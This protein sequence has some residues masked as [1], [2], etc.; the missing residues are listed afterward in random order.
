MEKKSI[1]RVVSLAVLLALLIGVM[2]LLKI[3]TGLADDAK[4]ISARVNGFPQTDGANLVDIM[5]K[6][7]LNYIESVE[8]VSGVITEADFRDLKA[9][10]L[11]S[12]LNLIVMKT[13]Q[14]PSITDPT[15]FDGCPSTRSIHVLS[16]MVAQY[17]AASDGDTSDTKWYGFDIVDVAPE[18]ML[19]GDKPHVVVDSKEII[20]VDLNVYAPLANQSPQDIAEVDDANKYKINQAVWST[21]ETGFVS[22][23]FEADK[24]YKTLIELKAESGYYFS[25]TIKPNLNNLTTYSGKNV[26]LTPVVGAVNITS[27]DTTND[28]LT[29]E[30][31][32]P[33]ASTVDPPKKQSSSPRA[34]AS[35]VLI[36]VDAP[37][38]GSALNLNATYTVTPPANF[39]SGAVIWKDARGNAV[40]SVPNDTTMS[41]AYVAE[42]TIV[43]SD[44]TFPT[45]PIVN[46]TPNTGDL[47]FY[48]PVISDIKVESLGTTL[49]FKATYT[50]KQ[51][52][53]PKA[54]VD[55][56]SPMG[57][58]TIKDVTKTAVTAT[59]QFTVRQNSTLWH[60]DTTPLTIGG[61]FPSSGK[62]KTQFVL[63]PEPG[64]TL[65]VG[66]EIFITDTNPA[67]VKLYRPLTPKKVLNPDGTLTVTVEYEYNTGAHVHDQ[68]VFDGP[69]IKDTNGNYTNIIDS[70]LEADVVLEVKGVTCSTCGEDVTSLCTFIWYKLYE[71]PGEQSRYEK[72]EG[73][74]YTFENDNKI[75][76]IK[77]ITK[78]DAEPR[79]LVETK[80]GTKVQNSPYV[81]IYLGDS[82]MPDPYFDP[83]IVNC[84]IG[85]DKT[86][87]VKSGLPDPQPSMKYEWRKGAIPA[88]GIPTGAIIG[89][90]SPTLILRNPQATDAGFY[91]VTVTN[92]KNGKSKPAQVE[93]KV[94]V[95]P[96]DLIPILPKDIYTLDFKAPVTGDTPVMLK[97]P[98][99]A[100]YTIEHKWRN[101]TSIVAPP[102]KFAAGK[103]YIADVTIIP[104]N[105]YRIGNVGDAF[106]EIDVMNNYLSKTFKE[107]GENGSYCRLEVKFSTTMNPDKKDQSQ[108]QYVTNIPE[109]KTYGDADF[110]VSVRGGSGD[111]AITFTS[112]D[113]KVLSV[114]DVKGNDAVISV[115]G[116]GTATI[117]ATKAGGKDTENNYNP[118]TVISNKITV[119]PKILVVKASDKTIK[120][121]MTTEVY[122]VDISGFVR[123]D[124]AYSLAGF[125]S[126]TAV[127]NIPK[128]EETVDKTTKK[129]KD[130]PVKTPAEIL[131]EEQAKLD[132]LCGKFEI[133]PSGGKPTSAYVF[134]Y[135]T[136]TLTINRTGI[137]DAPPPFENFI[138]DDSITIEDR[139]NGI[140][141]TDFSEKGIFKAGTQLCVVN[142][143]YTLTDEEKA[144]YNA[145]INATVKGKQL[146]QIYDIS[147]KLDGTPIQPNDDVLVDID[148]ASNLKGRYTDLQIAY[149][150]DYGDITIMPHAVNADKITFLTDHF[151]KYAI[152]G[153][154]RYGA[155][156]GGGSGVNVIP[157]G[158]GSDVPQT[159]DANP[160]LML[161]IGLAVIS[162]TTIIK[163]KS[164]EKS[165]VDL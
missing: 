31:T 135:V 75:L 5:T 130:E 27:V 140:L 62:F 98:A 114:K 58:D 35:P 65:S 63:V 20:D 153:T 41:T 77:G 100:N 89:Q 117:T 64:Y 112:S 40:T 54:S 124:N 92:E 2:P 45:T 8:V 102:S 76:K 134:R 144:L 51:N 138:R 79:Y 96:A 162:G 67:P 163:I 69:P 119:A 15:V 17:R 131:A 108:L 59:E 53:I 36:N 120:A 103:S 28:T 52:N 159:S 90:N 29:F 156:S 99:N 6:N 1:R 18:I 154:S 14:V 71:K 127:A 84:D 22:G 109:R 94:S 161:F 9:K 43:I 48:V 44:D 56:W 81:T 150:S 39:V 32:Y 30:V 113:D 57:A 73:P 87:E 16:S 132:K 23:N 152:I 46:V 83:P 125:E 137:A 80:C 160:Y 105:G 111:G 55:I 97:A 34:V 33:P 10:G 155:G 158:N 19:P 61:T 37:V 136:G 122:P 139:K 128:V 82:S 143:T 101:A 13:M 151:S 26:A 93:V 85:V 142:E 47:Y 149:I 91:N 88:N 148:L 49:K 157:G 147:L 146:A 25:A 50:K 74:R 4:P 70:F 116:G 68:L 118:A 86:L 104:K 129:K 42:V 7:K 38:P 115:V 121:G 123:G 24:S 21:S 3:T 66:T 165:K 72:V 78:D 164:S 95:A 106:I 12:Q 11:N 110:A 133:V 107:M 145:N 60:D 141:L 126:P